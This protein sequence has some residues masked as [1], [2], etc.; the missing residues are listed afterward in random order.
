MPI[1]VSKFPLKWSELKSPAKPNE[2]QV[3]GV[4][5]LCGYNVMGDTIPYCMLL[6]RVWYCKVQGGIELWL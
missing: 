3:S 2:S 1:H 4:A 6:Y 5:V